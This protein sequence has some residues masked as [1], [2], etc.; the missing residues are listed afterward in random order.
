MILHTNSQCSKL[1]RIKALAYTH[2]L[3][4]ISLKIFS[5]FKFSV[6]YDQYGAKR[7]IRRH[8]AYVIYVYYPVAMEDIKMFTNPSVISRNTLS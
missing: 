5:L 7:N 1:H 3:D 4:V 8:N 2:A 6:T